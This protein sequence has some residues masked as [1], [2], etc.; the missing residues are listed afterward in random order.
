MACAKGVAT[1]TTYRGSNWK[2]GIKDDMVYLE[3][4]DGAN[5][6]RI[7]DTTFDTEQARGLAANLIRAADRLDPR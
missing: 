5:E 7:L 3:L 6:L 2:T 4:W 1:V